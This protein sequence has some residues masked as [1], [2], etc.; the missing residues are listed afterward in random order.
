MLL[1]WGEEGER[2]D[3][4]AQKLKSRFNKMYKIRNER[5]VTKKNEYQSFSIFLMDKI[6]T[7]RKS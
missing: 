6:N 5:F 2:E 7:G 3:K 1:S 4:K